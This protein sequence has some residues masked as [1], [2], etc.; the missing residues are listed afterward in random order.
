MNKFF[1]AFLFLIAVSMTATTAKIARPK[2][3]LWKTLDLKNTKVVD[4]IKK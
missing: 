4:K 3:N 1:I 2:R